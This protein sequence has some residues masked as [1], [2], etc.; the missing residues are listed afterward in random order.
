MPPLERLFRYEVRWLARVLR[1]RSAYRP[2]RT[3]L[4]LARDSGPLSVA[5]ARTQGN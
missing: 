5:R 1:G 2:M 3:H 4:A